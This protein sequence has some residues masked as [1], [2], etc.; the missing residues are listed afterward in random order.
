MGDLIKQIKNIFCTFKFT[1]VESSLLDLNRP[2]FLIC[3]ATRRTSKKEIEF[4]HL[5]L[6]QT[7]QILKKTWTM[8]MLKLCSYMVINNTRSLQIYQVFLS[9]LIKNIALE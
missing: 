9:C 8:L 5:R 2:L 4:K 7:D 1:S 6:Q 3:I